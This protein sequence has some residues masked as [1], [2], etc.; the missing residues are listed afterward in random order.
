M[1]SSPR[2]PSRV[3]PAASPTPGDDP[4]T[5]TAAIYTPPTS[6]TKMPSQA[7]AGT[8]FA[9]AIVVLSTQAIS[10]PVRAIF[11]PNRAINSV[12]SHSGHK[13]SRGNE[14]L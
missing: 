4:V 11:S 8:S 13:L 1:A 9:R 3:A 12:S 10:L 14:C 7:V 6:A 5:A 2:S